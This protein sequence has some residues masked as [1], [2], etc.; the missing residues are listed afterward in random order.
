MRV[1]VISSGFPGGKP[2]VRVWGPAV[3]YLP[4]GMQETPKASSVATPS[5]QQ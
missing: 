3:A 1:I 4:A 5:F 2:K